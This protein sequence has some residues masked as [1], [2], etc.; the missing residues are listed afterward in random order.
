M[1]LILIEYFFNL[2]GNN[3]SSNKKSQHVN[4]FSSYNDGQSYRGSE[5]THMESHPKIMDELADFLK[6]KGHSCAMIVGA[7]NHDFTWCKKDECPETIMLNNMHLQ[8]QKEEEFAKELRQ[9]GHTC[10]YIMESYPMQ[11]GWCHQDS[12]VNSK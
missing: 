7:S 9:K 12:C 3:K 2:M 1:I 5:N 11:V 8:Q 10:V 4:D 6:Q